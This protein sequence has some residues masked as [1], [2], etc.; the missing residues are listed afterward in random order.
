MNKENKTY[1]AQSDTAIT[2]ININPNNHLDSYARLYLAVARKQI[3]DRLI[4]VYTFGCPAANND[5]FYVK[6]TTDV[7]AFKN[8]VHADKYIAQVD[9][10]M[11]F[12][13]QW[14]LFSIACNALK[15][16][17]EQFYERTK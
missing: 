13:S 3:S 14:P 10:V 12:Q 16:E 1:P 2:H 4:H 6:A 15:L 8:S 11:Q 7:A 5:C 9:Q 17:L